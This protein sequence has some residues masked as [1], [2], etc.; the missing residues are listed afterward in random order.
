M[1]NHIDTLS[2]KTQKKQIDSTKE[3]SPLRKFTDK[4]FG[5]FNLTWP[6]IILYAIGA[7]VLTTIFLVVPIFKDT[8][9]AKMGET[10]ETWVLL[11]IIII[12]NSKNPLDS[13]LKTFVFFL[14]SQPLIYLFQVPFSWQGWGIFQYYKYWFIV[15]LCTFPAAYIGWYIKKKNWL[16]LLIL[17]PI[18]I[19][20]AMLCNDSMKQAIYN[21]P[22]LLLTV[23]FCIAQILLYLY[24][25]TEKIPQKIIGLLIP[26]T[27]II[28][29]LLIP[30]TVDFTSSQFLPDDPILTDNAIVTVDNPEVVD[31]KISSS[32]EDG[33]TIQTHVH[34]YDTTS[35]IIKD[36]DREY[37]Y[38][39]HIYE[40]NLGVSQIDITSDN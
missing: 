12:A 9:F 38:N 39:I 3:K 35:F 24:V 30:K 23:I 11:A 15:T 36:G 28:I 37:H 13:A 18:L 16:S 29:M 2:E 34:A 22:H 4:L 17:T 5:G 8:S 25:F 1:S 14:I 40:D 20:L 26:I 7:A 33:T 6:S 32:G 10:L 21:F 19:L 27:T 31:I